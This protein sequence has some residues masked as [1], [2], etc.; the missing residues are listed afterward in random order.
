MRTYKSIIISALALVFTLPTMAQTVDKEAMYIYLYD[1]NASIFFRNQVTAISLEMKDGV[2]HQ[3]VYTG[4]KP[5]YFPIS[6]IQSMSFVNPDEDIYRPPIG[7][8]EDTP[9]FGKAIDLGLPSG[10]K[11][12]SCNVGATSPEE[13][14]GYYAWGEVSEKAVYNGVTYQYSSS[15]SI[16]FLF[17]GFD[18]HNTQ[19]DVAHVNWG[20]HWRMPMIQQCQELVNNCTYKFITFHGV[21]GGLFKSKAN[22]KSIFLPAAGIRWDGN[23]HNQYSGYYWSSQAIGNGK[24]YVGILFFNSVRVRWDSHD[25]RSSGLSVRPV[26]S[27]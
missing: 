6:K 3:V 12:A 20:Y 7:E 15:S 18:I 4:S 11:W 27:N 19:Y 14:G 24:D 2:M 5:Y 10:T 9:T 23:L 1:G 13:Y 22:G 17:L 21:K 8:D 26:V 16:D 25:I